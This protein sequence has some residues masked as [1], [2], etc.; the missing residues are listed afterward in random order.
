MTKADDVGTEDDRVVEA[1]LLGLYE[2]IQRTLGI[3]EVL[4]A[5][6]AGAAEVLRRLKERLQA[7]PEARL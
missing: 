3:E 7:D 5:D 2:A 4:P 6:A 1:R